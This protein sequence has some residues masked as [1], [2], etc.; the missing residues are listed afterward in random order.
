MAMQQLCSGSFSGD[1]KSKCMSYDTERARQLSQ[2]RR[3]IS[4]LVW[5]RGATSSGAGAVRVIDTHDI[6]GPRPDSHVGKGDCT[7]YYVGSTGWRWHVSAVLTAIIN[8]IEV[9]DIVVATNGFVPT[10]TS[11]AQSTISHMAFTPPAT[12]RYGGDI[13]VTMVT[14]MDRLASSGRLGDWVAASSFAAVA[15]CAT[16]VVCRSSDGVGRSGKGAGG[17]VEGSD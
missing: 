10:A 12:G 15:C 17:V 6:L 1:R 16:C 3:N 5:S 13:C 11:G 7:H 9:E 14:L 2:W 4:Q 8:A